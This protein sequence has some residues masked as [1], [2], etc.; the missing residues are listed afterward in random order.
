MFTN[1]MKEIIKMFV[2][3]FIT[4]MTIAGIFHCF[5]YESK[6]EEAFENGYEQAI[7]EA[8]LV[9]VEENEYIISFNGEEHIYSSSI[10][11]EVMD[12][13]S[14]NSYQKAIEDAELVESND[15]GYTLSVN[16][17]VNWYTFD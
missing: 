5:T 1:E 11:K 12:E 3:A 14:K 17:E 9:S 10:G 2:S 13:A 15:E 6:I 7:L 4:A 8:E 16:G